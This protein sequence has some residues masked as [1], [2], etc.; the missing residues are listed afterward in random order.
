M[1]PNGAVAC[2]SRDELVA[3]LRRLRADGELRR[4]LAQ[5]GVEAGRRDFDAKV[6]AADFR[7]A[8]WEDTS[9]VLSKHRLTSK[10]GMSAMR[11][12]FS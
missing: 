6:I 5:R 10:H 2:A 11:T 12:P 3:V 4:D 7:N 8:L 9:F 1:A